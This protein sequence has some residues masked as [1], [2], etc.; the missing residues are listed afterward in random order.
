MCTRACALLFWPGIHSTQ[1]PVQKSEFKI[2]ISSRRT[3]G[4]LWRIEELGGPA[5]IVT[6][7]C[8]L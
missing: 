1:E 5:V 8:L 2:P 4:F 7:T 6:F 3:D